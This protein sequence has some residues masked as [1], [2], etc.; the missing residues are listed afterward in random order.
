MEMGAPT[1]QQ[2]THDTWD[3]QKALDEANLDGM[4]RDVKMRKYVQKFASPA[5]DAS[6]L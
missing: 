6:A 1:E 5:A 4:K 2:I 3:C